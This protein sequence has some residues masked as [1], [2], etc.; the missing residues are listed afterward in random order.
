MDGSFVGPSHR[1]PLCRTAS[2]RL[3]HRLFLTQTAHFDSLN[4]SNALGAT[5]DVRQGHDLGALLRRSVVWRLRGLNDDHLAVVI[6][7]MLLWVETYRQ[8]HYRWELENVFM[9]D[10]ITRI[11]NLSREQRAD[12]SEPFFYDFVRTCRKRG[13]GLLLATQ[14]PGLLPPPLLANLS[15]W[16]AFKPVDAATIRVLTSSMGLS[17]EHM[18][19]FLRLT[20]AQGR[21]IAVRHP[22]HSW[23]FLVCVPDVPVEV[24]PVAVV[25]EAVER[26]RA[27]LGPGSDPAETVEELPG[28]EKEDEG[29]DTGRT[30]AIACGLAPWHPRGLVG[31]V[32]YSPTGLPQISTS[33]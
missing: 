10:E 3:R 30:R 17:Q 11:C 6:G 33:M 4:G 23:P 2:V 22:A 20:P 5:L 12:I 32:P 1:A 28:L 18:D 8:V 26:T 16:Y 15:T 7:A 24:A 19:Y 21:T 13:I 29:D 14:T 9:F 31:V 27:W 25:A